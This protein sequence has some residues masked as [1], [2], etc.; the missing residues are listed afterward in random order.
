V[1]KGSVSG[2]LSS[3][4]SPSDLADFIIARTLVAFWRYVNRQKV[5]TQPFETVH[6]KAAPWGAASLTGR[7]LPTAFCGVGGTHWRLAQNR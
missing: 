7:K 1:K 4:F 3:F 5:Q 6:K 2:T